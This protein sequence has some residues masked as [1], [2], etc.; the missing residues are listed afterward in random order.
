MEPR[1][2]ED[3]KVPPFWVPG[4]GL[5]SHLDRNVTTGERAS[6]ARR[7]HRVGEGQEV[8]HSFSSALGSPPSASHRW[9]SRKKQQ[10][11]K[12]RSP[13]TATCEAEQSRGRAESDPQ[14]CD[15]GSGMENGAEEVKPDFTVGL[16]SSTSVKS[17]GRSQNYDMNLTLLI[18]LEYDHPWGL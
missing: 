7:E 13:A 1:S 4:L 15:Q 8:Y 18:I 17:S 3:T 14:N 5:C 10:P 9:N 12:G 2:Q 11:G 6:G 16:Y